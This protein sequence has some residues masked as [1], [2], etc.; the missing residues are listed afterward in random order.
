MDPEPASTPP[1]LQPRPEPSEAVLPAG[2]RAERDDRPRPPA[3]RGRRG[4]GRGWL[5]GLLGLAAAMG[6]AWYWQDVLR[7]ELPGT[8]FNHILV[9]AG[10][11]LE[12]GQLLGEGGARELYQAALAQSPDNDLARQGLARVGA[13]LLERAR[14]RLADGDREGARADLEAA[15]ALLGGGSLV[16]ALEQEL[17]AATPAVDE[18]GPLLQQADDA[19]QAGRLTGRDGAAAL[20]RQILD[21]DPH[22]ALA[23]A[24]LGRVAAALAARVRTA[25]AA[26]DMQAAADGLDAIDRLVP[27]WPGLTGLRGEMAAAGE[28][29]RQEVAGLLDRAEA[30]IADGRLTEGRASARSLLAQA[31]ALDPGNARA[32][33]LAVDAARTLLVQARAALEE[34]RA[35][36]AEGLLGQA[37][38]FAPQLPELSRAQ[39]ELQALRERLNRPLEGRELTPAES[40]QLQRLADQAEHA[41]VAGRL[42]LPPGDSAWDA[43]RAMQA[44]DPHNAAA[45][46]GLARLPGHARILFDQALAAGRPQGARQYLDAVRQVAP[47]DP[48][49]PSM[50]R[51]LGGA[52]LDQA[53]ARLGDGRAQDAAQ[54]LAMA[55]ELVPDE[56]RLARLESRLRAL[57]AGY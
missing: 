3:R 15:R 13:Q 24:G 6:A 12:A 45:A 11:A 14:G 9:E 17:A 47:S 31:T 39:A 48:A 43:Y 34:S 4:R 8:R 28:R 23:V 54:V 51:R 42:I 25:L 38:R 7:R 41:L 19:L 2:L 33:R 21:E 32:S 5:A 18:A 35:E 27:G 56:P 30:A 46:E 22:N 37:A 44:L 52:L 29:R 10:R 57:Q 16:E 50:T 40:A 55:R 49:L 1:P 36:R 20:Y 26:G 53:D